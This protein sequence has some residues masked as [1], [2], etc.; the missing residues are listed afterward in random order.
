MSVTNTAAAMIFATLYP[1][2]N[3]PFQRLIMAAADANNLKGKKQWVF[4]G[5]D[6]GEI[7]FRRFRNILVNEIA[8][9]FTEDGHVSDPANPSEVM[10]A[11]MKAKRLFQDAYPNW[12]DAYAFIDWFYEK[13]N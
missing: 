6:R 12:H 11:M 8:F 9:T 13:V 4:F 7:A 2:T 10:D 3:E 1:K 5:G